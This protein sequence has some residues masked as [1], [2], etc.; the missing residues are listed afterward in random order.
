MGTVIGFLTKA[1]GRHDLAALIQLGRITSRRDDSI[2]IS[3]SFR[4]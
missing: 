4:F 2:P 1:Y 3:V